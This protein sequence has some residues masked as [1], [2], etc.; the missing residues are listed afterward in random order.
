MVGQ[1]LEARVG[2]G[3][4]EYDYSVNGYLLDGG[5]VSDICR[6]CVNR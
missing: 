3:L 4:D 2:S 5:Q 6:Y 1:V